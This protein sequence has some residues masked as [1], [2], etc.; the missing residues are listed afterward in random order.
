MCIRDR[1]QWLAA[2]L[3]D[4]GLPPNL[5][6]CELTESQVMDDPVLAMNVISQLKEIGV[7]TAI[8]DFGTGYSSLSYLRRLPVDEIKIDKSFVTGMLAD[9]TDTT[10]VRTIVDLAHNLGMAVLAEGVEDQATLQRLQEFGCDRIQGYLVG[11]PA[12][13][14]EMDQLV[15]QRRLRAV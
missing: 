8:D 5:L 2:S 10:I 9:E 14:A 6:K 13:A 3:D 1:V 7:H 15:G 12:P 4:L 11:R